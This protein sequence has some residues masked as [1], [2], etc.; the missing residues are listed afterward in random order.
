M[1]GKSIIAVSDVHLG[2]TIGKDR[3][4]EEKHRE[5]QF[6]DYGNPFLARLIAILSAITIITYSG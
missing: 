1:I 2:L 4:E 6:G 5:A 3:P